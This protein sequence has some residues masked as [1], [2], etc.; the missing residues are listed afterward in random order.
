MTQQANPLLDDFE[1]PAF[2]AIRPEHINPAIDQLLS[3]Y[4]RRVEQLIDGPG[5]RDFQSLMAPLEALAERL[6]RAWAPIGHLH[7]VKDSPALREAYNAAQEKLTEH[8]TELGQNR[9]LFEAVEAVRQSAEFERLD[10]AQ[11]ALIEDALREFRLSGVALEEP[12]R[13][14]FKAIQTELSTLATGFSEAVLD[15]TDSW[16]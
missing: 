6:G 4:R 16:T 9:A 12:Q 15:A 1:L 14:R 8:N 7:G 5:E 13:S 2:S 3:D 11:R 10:R